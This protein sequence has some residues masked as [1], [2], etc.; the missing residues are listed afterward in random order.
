MLHW[1]SWVFMSCEYKRSGTNSGGKG[2]VRGKDFRSIRERWALTRILSHWNEMKWNAKE[3]QRQRCIWLL[4]YFRG[5]HVSPVPFLSPKWQPWGVVLCQ[6]DP[7]LGPRS[8]LGSL[9]SPWCQVLP[10][11]P[12]RATLSHLAARVL[13]EGTT[14]MWPQPKSGLQHDEA[15]PSICYVKLLLAAPCAGGLWV[16]VTTSK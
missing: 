13:T 8:P 5:V 11:H 6:G 10:Q 3:A 12:S 1:G 9:S 4:H 14:A 2:E 7:H 16:A 15:Q